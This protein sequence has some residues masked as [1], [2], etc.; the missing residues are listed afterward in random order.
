ME[1]NQLPTTP[2]QCATLKEWR[3][4]VLGL[5]QLEVANLAGVKQ[6]RISDVETGRV[7]PR[8][9]HWGRLILGMQKMAPDAAGNQQ[10]M[11]TESEFYRMVAAA[12]RQWLQ[13][14]AWATDQGQD[15]LPLFK[16]TDEA[17]GMND[18]RAVTPEIE[19]SDRRRLRSLA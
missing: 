4:L 15:E 17:I 11:L 6:S 19:Q 2:Q 10:P 7:K 9:K 3:E 12:R 16:A 14:H 13:R 18:V 1:T 5:S 8:K